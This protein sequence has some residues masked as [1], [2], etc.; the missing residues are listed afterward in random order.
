MGD[1]MNWK[2]IP[3]TQGLVAIVDELDY[4]RLSAY[5]WH[6]RWHEST[7]S[8]YA[9]RQT[10]RKLGKQ[11]SIQMHREIMCAVPGMQVDHVNCDTLDNRRSNLRFATNAQNVMNSGVRRDNQS[12]LKG[13]GKHKSGWTARITV[14]GKTTYLGLFRTPEEA[15]AAYS[16]AAKIMHGEFARVK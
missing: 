5:K 14:S 16:S 11:H 10:S 2:T 7:Q 9:Q 8:H 13:V 6:A 12:G 3:L 4:D 1:E 15:H